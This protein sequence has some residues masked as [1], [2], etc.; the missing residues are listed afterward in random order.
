M[1]NNPYKNMIKVLTP[2]KNDR[3]II[4]RVGDNVYMTETH[5]AYKVRYSIYS[6]W[7]HAEKPFI[8][9][10]LNDGDCLSN[11]E[12]CD[13]DIQDCMKRN[14][15]SRYDAIP[16]DILKDIHDRFAR[17]FLIETD[18]GENVPLIID[19][20]F[21]QSVA[22]FLNDSDCKIT[23]C[24]KS[25]Y[26]IWIECD[27]ITALLLPINYGNAG[28]MPSHGEALAKL[29]NIDTLSAKNHVA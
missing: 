11:G 5:V 2:K 19:E 4:Q 22:P 1:R 16:T 20:R 9:P 12:P 15:H 3:L 28:D 17:M 29:A 27:A 26:P 7:I 13:M 14:D 23:S 8:F 21:Y 10:A 25:N 18:Y 6:A 24:G